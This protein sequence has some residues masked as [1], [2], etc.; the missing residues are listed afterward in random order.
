MYY[1]S[2]G[3]HYSFESFLKIEPTKK[4]KKNKANYLPLHY[5]SNGLNHFNI[6]LHV[7]FTPTFPQGTGARTRRILKT[8]FSFQ[9]IA[10]HF[11]P[12]GNF[13]M[14]HGK[15]VWQSVHIYIN[16]Y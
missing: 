9:Q 1:K 7:L 5:K 6:A 14:A 11:A 15:S 3:T 10:E 12:H 8:R 16:P 4:T 2:N 13:Y